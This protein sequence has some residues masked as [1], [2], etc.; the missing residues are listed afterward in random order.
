MLRL[1]PFTAVRRFFGPIERMLAGIPSLPRSL[2]SLV[3][4]GLSP[5]PPPRDLFAV[6]ALLA[7]RVV[8]GISR[9]IAVLAALGREIPLRQASALRGAALRLPLAAPGSGTPAWPSWAVIATGR[10][11]L[12]SRVGAQRRAALRRPVSARLSP[13]RTCQFPGIRLSMRGLRRGCCQSGLAVQTVPHC[14]HFRVASP[15]GYVVPAVADHDAS[16]RIWRSATRD[17]AA[18]LHPSLAPN[19]FSFARLGGDAIAA[20][21]RPRRLAMLLAQPAQHPIRQR[22]VQLAELACC[23]CRVAVIGPP[24]ED[25]RVEVSNELG[26]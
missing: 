10:R 20:Q 2:R 22:P 25:D 24:A 17:E 14:G 6:F 19:E 12:N 5:S 23:P 8:S 15:F 3:Q 18:Q 21:C 9:R 11:P 7:A 13:N 1:L 16:C 26:Q 4:T